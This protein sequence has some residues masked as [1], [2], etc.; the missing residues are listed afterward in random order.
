MPP[1]LSKLSQKTYRSQNNEEKDDPDEIYTPSI[2]D[3]DIESEINP[4]ESDVNYKIQ[5]VQST[6]LRDLLDFFSDAKMINP[7]N[8]PST[9]I[10]DRQSLKCYNVP[11]KKLPKMFKY[12]EAC[13]RAK[14]IRMMFE[15]RQQDPSGIMLDF[16]IYQDTETS[17]ITDEILYI[18]CQKIIELLMTLLH[19]KDLKKEMFYIGITRRPTITYNDEKECYKD[20]FHLLIPSIKISRGLKRLLVTKLVKGELIDQLLADVEPAKIDIKGETYQRKDFLDKNSAHVPTFFIGSATKKGNAPYVLT[21]I[22]ETTVN[23]ETKSIMMI[24]NE[25]LMKSKNFNVCHEFSIN[26]E[27]PNG[28][29][30]KI[31]Y[32]PNDKYAAEAAE[33][34]RP[35][36]DVEEHNRNFGI[37]STNA[38][39]D[40]QINEIKLLLDT[41]SPK[42]AE[43]YELWRDVIFA[44]ASTSSSYKDLAEYFS[45]KGSNF[46]MTAFESLWYSAVKGPTRGRK[47][48]TLGTIHYWAKIDNPE[49]Y[50]QLRKDTVY[51]ILYNMVHEGYKEGILSH[52]DVSE[53]IFRLLKFK[54]VTDIPYGERKRVWFEFILD[55]D[56]YRD[57][58]LYKWRLWRDEYPISL[59]RYISEV[60][61]NLFEL[62]FKSVKKNYEKSSGDI[63]K[64][65]RKVL[66]NFK[67]T[68]RK[69]GDKTFIRNVINMAEIKFSK[70]GFAELLDKNPIIRGVSN[71]VLKLG[72]NNQP[73]Q[74][75]QG[76]HTHL[77]SKYTDVPYV[78]FNPYDPITKKILITLR[79]MFPDNESDTFAFTMAFLASTLD[80]NPK[81]SMFMIMVGQGANG[82][83][84]LVELHTSAIGEI[85]GVKMPLSYL[86]AKNTSPDNA[87]PSM[88]MLKDAT[89]AYYSESEKHE[90]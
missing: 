13:R 41:L 31:V 54:Y 46:N 70:I 56:D 69:L 78:P 1:K 2:V 73:P 28:V 68:M 86:T 4:V 27:C 71:G 63:S 29:I 64:Y 85:Y 36:K 49:R 58:E 55:D 84:F 8:D 35:N 10:I 66:D 22:Y 75:I 32:E 15:E 61:P 77:I 74:L 5:S 48:F 19:F 88:M 42:R 18:L 37:L 9:N 24:K 52:A 11:E 89:F 38:V 62:V 60:L 79:S 7:S 51:S 6:Q 82:K 57:G 30:K 25:S 40:A 90:V 50:T 43:D 12:L 81:E 23:F 20:G 45:R 33:L 59:I 65:Y 83:T 34:S 47:G 87:T 17:Q 72:W 80:G 76:Y 14:N 39:H 44:L 53:I 16:D 26:F 3:S 67:A 21:H